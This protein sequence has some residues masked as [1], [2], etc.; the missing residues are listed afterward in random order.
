MPFYKSKCIHYFCTFDKKYLINSLKMT[1]PKI[2]KKIQI[3]K[4]TVKCSK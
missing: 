1:F 3:K 4:K 2:Y